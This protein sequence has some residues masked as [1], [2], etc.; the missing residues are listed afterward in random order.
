MKRVI[1]FIALA[2]IG[3][4]TLMYAQ[5][6]NKTR[7]AERKAQRAAEKAREKAED[8]R[9]YAVAVQALQDGKFVL[10]ADQLVFKRGRIAYI[11][12]TTNFVMMNGNQASVQIASNGAFAGPNGIGGITVDGSTRSLKITT[13]KKGNVNCSF[14]V[15]GVG[16]SA[17]VFITI[18]N[19]NSRASARISPNYNSNT[20][21]LNG[22]LIPLSQSTVYKGYSL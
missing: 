5:S 2:L 21:T 4:S 8:E 12:P 19:G 3:A 1:T 22:R 11:S 15:Q 9:A 13:D 7:H 6:G 17:Q 18:S 20:L 16:I 10:E 14:S